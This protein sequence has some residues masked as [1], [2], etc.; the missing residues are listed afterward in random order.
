MSST[1]RT[2]VIKITRFEDRR[3]VSQELVI[4]TINRR[5]GWDR[6]AR[7][8]MYF[9]MRI[10]DLGKIYTCFNEVLIAVEHVYTENSGRNIEDLIRKVPKKKKIVQATEV[11]EIS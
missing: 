4:L 7:W 11:Q 2:S 3:E 10:A 9:S 1:T 8:S 5:T 6:K